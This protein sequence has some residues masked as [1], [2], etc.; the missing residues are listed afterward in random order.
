MQQEKSSER[1]A[2]WTPP[3]LEDNVVNVY[4]WVVK[5]K[6]NLK[7]GKKTDIGAFSYLQAEEGIEIGEN[8][9]IGSHCSIYSVSSIDGKRGKVT[10][11]KNACIGSHCTIMPGIT[12]GKNAMV[13]AH[14]FVNH[15]IPDGATAYGVPVR[16]QI[17]NDTTFTAN[18]DIRKFIEREKDVKITAPLGQWASCR[19][20]RDRPRKTI[21]L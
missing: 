15:N 3:I 5:Y 4:H 2:N 7:L 8:S 9:Q 18:S 1:F 14:S 13:G 16:I 17:K 19:K 6:D 10:I 11:G 20:V 12:I 21:K